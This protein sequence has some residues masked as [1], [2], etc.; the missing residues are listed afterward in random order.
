M[1]LS[2]Q[3]GQVLKFQ[4]GWGL[5]V[6]AT[7]GV[8]GL[9]TWSSHVDSTFAEGI[10]KLKPAR[11]LL[12]PKHIGRA[13]PSAS[14]SVGGQSFGGCVRTY[15]LEVIRLLLTPHRVCRPSATTE[16]CDLGDRGL[17]ED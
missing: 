8:S 15:S 16:V 5:V 12:H 7:F 4:E 2:P 11:A 6:L 17:G 3:P 14:A 10:T 13:L 1:I 9:S